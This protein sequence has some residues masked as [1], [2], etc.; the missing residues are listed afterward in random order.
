MKKEDKDQSCSYVKFNFF[1]KVLVSLHM[2]KNW[3]SIVL[4]VQQTNS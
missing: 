2:E 4:K 1:W 3:P